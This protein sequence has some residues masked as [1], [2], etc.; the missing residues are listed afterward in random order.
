MSSL[1]VELRRDAQA[2]PSRLKAM[3]SHTARTAVRAVVA[4]HRASL[5]RLWDIP[6]TVL[7][8]AGI[9]FASFHVNHGVGFLVTG[10]SLLV[11][12]HMI[13]D[14]DDGSAA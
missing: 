9:D 4:P 12:E 2:K 5:A 1:T 13:S 3:L 7:G 14:S 10:L 8:T 6:L 11:I